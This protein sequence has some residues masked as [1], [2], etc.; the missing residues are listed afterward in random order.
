MSVSAQ[1]EPPGTS[2]PQAPR[3]WYAGVTHY[4]WLVLAVASAGWIFDVYQGQIFNLTRDHLLSD[5]LHVGKTD[6][7]IKNY[8]DVFLAIFLVGGAAG[9]VLFGSLA[10]RF[11]RRPMIAA[12][13]LVYSIFSGLTYFAHSLWEVGA[14][15]FLVA[16]GVGGEWAVAA[17]LVAEVFPKEARAH[18]SGIFHATSVLGTWAAT[19]AGIAIGAQWRYGYLI[20]IAPALLVFWVATSIKEPEQWSK[21]A[22]QAKTAAG[23]GARMG[24][25][26]ELLG[27]AKWRRRAILGMLLAAVGLGSFWAVTVA[28]QDL[29]KELLLR[30]GVALPKAVRQAQF[31][32]GIVQTI[33][34]GLGLL[35]MGPLC[36]WLGRRRAFV[37]MH[38]A[39]FVIV[40]ITCYLPGT[41][42]Q[43][44]VLLPL[45]GFLT[46]GIHA[47]Y[48][49]YFPELFPTHLRASGSGFCFNGG[50]IVA[51]SALVLSGWLKSLPGMDL[52]LAITLLG[53][54][55]PLGLLVILF[56]PETK[57]QPLPE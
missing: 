53:L 55:F 51:A 4:Q 28:G 37:V 16:M 45:F 30:N 10:D 21:L 43:L 9:G 50:R 11:G 12:T 13:I 17:S 40:P 31:A 5:I 49:I 25:L 18:A 46:L 38:I 47:G 7:A 34:G 48:A 22:G 26:G 27:N 20:G 1:P 41:Y 8:G 3:P 29:A 14:T 24:S 32:Y 33:G 44:L 19:L 6:P 52:R 15:R 54:L 39:A 42:W 23:S 57:G 56:L 2:S 36:V 35:S